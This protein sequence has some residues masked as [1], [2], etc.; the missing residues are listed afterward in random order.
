MISWL[1]LLAS[2]L[3]TTSRTVAVTFD[4][5]PAASGHV[6]QA[7]LATLTNDLLAS[8][9]RNRVPAVGF[10]NEGKLYDDAG[11]I[12][13]ARVKLLEQWIQAGHDLG[14]HTFGH[15]DVDQTSLACCGAEGM[16]SFHSNRRSPIPY[17]VN[18]PIAT[19]VLP[20]SPGYIAGRSAGACPLLSS[21]A[22][23][24]FRRS[25]GSSDECASRNGARVSAC[26][27][28]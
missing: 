20:G 26:R 24:K 25:S 28:T 9:S 13:T 3:P 27:S 4:D 16:R 1:L 23:L 8:L 21:P 12:D 15:T 6:D 11:G 10:V 7:T 14:N 5:L 2:Q 22:S 18:I 19:S 17:I